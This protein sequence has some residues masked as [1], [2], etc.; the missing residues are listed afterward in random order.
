MPSSRSLS[1]NA[2]ELAVIIP[3]SNKAKNVALHRR[4]SA[5]L[6]DKIVYRMVSA[7]FVLFA[8]VGAVGVLTQL[9][10]LRLGLDTLGIAFPAAQALAT[11]AAMTGNYLL[12]N[13][14]TYR[15]R[16][17]RGRALLRGLFAFFAVCG[18]GAAANVVIAS[19][20]FAGGWRWWLA[21]LGGAALSAVWSYAMSSALVWRN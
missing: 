20:L 9:V 12:N 10:F 3:T 16:R 17:L 13:I 6:L 5:L 19:H 21:G 7:R 2:A 8:A 15:D 11:L 1:D 14:V 4:Y 18:V